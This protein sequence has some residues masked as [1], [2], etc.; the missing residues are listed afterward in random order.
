M[1]DTPRRRNKCDNAR[2]GLVGH[3]CGGSRNNAFEA[4]RLSLAAERA[5]RRNVLRSGGILGE[6]RGNPVVF[7]RF[8]KPVGKSRKVEKARDLILGNVSPAAP[9]PQIA[10]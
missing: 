5:G 2:V 8:E 4:S 10:I 3:N 7:I 6:K 1:E 9:T